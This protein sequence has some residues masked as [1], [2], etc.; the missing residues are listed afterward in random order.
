MG[1]FAKKEDAISAEPKKLSAKEQAKVDEREARNR[2]KALKWTENQVAKA[3][4]KGKLLRAAQN[5]DRKELLDAIEEGKTTIPLT[6]P[7]GEALPEQ[8]WVKEALIGGLS[9]LLELD[10]KVSKDVKI[11]VKPEEN[12]DVKVEDANG[13]PK[14]VSAKAEKKAKALELKKV[15][16]KEKLAITELDKAGEGS[17]LAACESAIA[18]A[19]EREVDKK[20]FDSC[21]DKA[22]ELLLAKASMK[23]I[24]YKIN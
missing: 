7:D 6:G 17:D 1:F 21:Q 2:E 13:K 12:K 14:K 11:D 24:V 9:K 10:G 15:S 22:I 20:H 5:D 19:L 18:T 16:E 23:P 3:Q 4:A 8:Y